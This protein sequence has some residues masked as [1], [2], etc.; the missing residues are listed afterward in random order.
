MKNLKWMVALL[1]T[2]SFTAPLM[3][4]SASALTKKDITKALETA[5]LKAQKKICAT[6][7]KEI[8]E[9]AQHCAAN[10]YISLCRA[11][12]PKT[13]NTDHCIYCNKEMKEKGQ[14][15]SAYGYVVLCSSSDKKYPSN[16]IIYANSICPDCGEELTIDERCHG[17]QHKCASACVSE[18][19]YCIYCGEEIKEANQHCS[20]QNYQGLCT[21]KC[22]DCGE[23][24]R[25]PKNLRGGKTHYCKFKMVITP[26]QPK[27]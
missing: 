4:Q 26:V 27:K 14:H 25:N 24:L 13:K 20:A 15:C 3:A 22:P 16:T 23:N 2:L 1:F 9:P 11:D 12:Q 21:V 7:G 19:D 8:K 18:K 10:G 6:C 17:A 5:A